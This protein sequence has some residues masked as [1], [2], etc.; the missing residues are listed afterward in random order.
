MAADR[1]VHSAPCHLRRIAADDNV[2]RYY[3]LTLEADLFGG[4]T[5][6]REWGRIGQDGAVKRQHFKDAAAA[7]RE[8]DRVARSK[9]RRGYRPLDMRGLA[10]APETR[11]ASPPPAGP[12]RPMRLRNARTPPAGG[13]NR[14][15]TVTAATRHAMRALQASTDRHPPPAEACR[16]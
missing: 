16:G 5:L 1:P 12:R 4:V 13:H 11:P 6:V 14:G 10:A 15:L 7:M 9:V 3:T 8:L 2:W